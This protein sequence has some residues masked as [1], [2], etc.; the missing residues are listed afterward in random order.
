MK[1]IIAVV[2]ILSLS[3]SC[4][5]ELGTLK[6]ISTKE[7]IMD[8]HYE[9]ALKQQ[10][11]SSNSLESAVELALKAVP[12][13]SFLKHTSIRSKGKKVTIV[14]DVWATSKKKKKKNDDLRVNKFN[15]KPQGIVTNNNLMPKGL[16]KLK[17]G[18]QVTWDHP[19][20]GVGSGVI[21]SISG[22]LA[23]IE[24]VLDKEGKPGKSVK[25][26]LEVLKP[27]KRR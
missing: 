4:T 6:N 21:V 15:K 1:K 7:L 24:K 16:A 3:V 20:A 13:A 22:M 18:M 25:L 10:T 11:Y 27:A 2:F 5:K 23:Q 19:K 14:T 9:L 8:Q 26:P 17:K 12:N